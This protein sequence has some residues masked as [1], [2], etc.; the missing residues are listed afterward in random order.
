MS[1]T[2]ESDMD[3]ILLQAVTDAASD[4]G[5]RGGVRIEDD[6]VNAVRDALRPRPTQKEYSAA[7]LAN[8]WRRSPGG[9]DLGVFHPSST[10][11]VRAIS[12][13]KVDKLDESLWDMIKMATLRDLEPSTPAAYLIYAADK[14]SFEH[15]CGFNCSQL[16]RMNPDPVMWETE[17]I[18]KRWGKAWSGTLTGSN[19]KGPE[20][21]NFPL[22][23]SK[24]LWTQ[25]ITREPPKV[26][27]STE[28]EIRILKVWT[29]GQEEIAFGDNGWPIGVTPNR[30]GGCTCPDADRP[31]PK[32]MSDSW[33]AYKVPT[34]A[35]D[36]YMQ[37]T[38]ELHR[39][40]WTSAELARRVHPHR[41]K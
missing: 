7:L 32:R 25:L 40:G 1:G 38:A 16:F 19:R 31:F 24:Y 13:M 28:Q 26:V 33:L 37:L 11:G 4:E 3:K 9:V 10:E 35:D 36:D 8:D 21:W 41:P 14:S 39:R 6:L 20:Y 34:M 12:E 5:L 2:R 30:D 23:C 22:N 17:Q 27:G 29:E 18:I 15:A